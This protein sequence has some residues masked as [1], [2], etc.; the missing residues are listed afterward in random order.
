MQTVKETPAVDLQEIKVEKEHEELAA[1]ADPY[2]TF[3]EY[4]E[5]VIKQ[6][7]EIYDNAMNPKT[8]VI[9]EVQRIK[10]EE[11]SVDSEEEE[12]PDTESD[13][14]LER[15]IHESNEVPETTQDPALA[16]QVPESQVQGPDPNSQIN[17]EIT[18]PPASPINNYIAESPIDLPELKEPAVTIHQFTSMDEIFLPLKNRF[19]RGLPDG[20]TGEQEL[21]DKFITVEMYKMFRLTHPDG[22]MIQKNLE[23][24]LRR[25]RDERLNQYSE[26][27]IQEIAEKEDWEEF[28]KAETKWINQALDIKCLAWQ[29]FLESASQNIEWFRK[30]A[31]K[32]WTDDETLQLELAL[33]EIAEDIEMQRSEDLD[34]NPDDFRFA[35]EVAPFNF[36]ISVENSVWWN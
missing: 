21:L 9:K 7:K 25:T 15:E 6:M 27:F 8:A 14:H 32:Q 5:T 20:P 22:I 29:Y 28:E 10:P 26:D 34:F 33:D 17:F 2:Q 18:S 1:Q 3:E 11:E 19:F 23:T 35:H 12:Y 36:M 13:T 30:M 31:P 4:K 16:T 24:D